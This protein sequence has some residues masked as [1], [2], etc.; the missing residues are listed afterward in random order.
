M[1]AGA[2]V[3]I[4]GGSAIDAAVTCAFVEG[5]VNPMNCGIGGYA[6]ATLHLASASSRRTSA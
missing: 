3:L 2:E 6:L 4:A 1:E 5:V